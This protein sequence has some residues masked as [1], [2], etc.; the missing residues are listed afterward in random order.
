[1][2]LRINHLMRHQR[3]KACLNRNVINT[4]LKLSSSSHFL[5]VIGRG[6]QRRGAEANIV[7]PNDIPDDL[8]ARIIHHQNA[9]P[10]SAD[11]YEVMNLGIDGSGTFLGIAV[12]A[13]STACKCNVE[14][15]L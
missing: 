10:A 3:S 8:G 4:F 6:F 2:V 5:R 11:I 13:C 12:S 7:M 14:I 1:M 9:D 15:L